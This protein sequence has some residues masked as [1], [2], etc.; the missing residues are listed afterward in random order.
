MDFVLCARP[1]GVLM[2]FEPCGPITR[3][4]AAGWR[5]DE[6]ADEMVVCHS[7]FPLSLFGACPQ[8]LAVIIRK[9]II[10]NNEAVVRPSARPP[11]CVSGCHIT[12][13]LQLVPTQ[14]HHYN[15]GSFR[16]LGTWATLKLH[17]RLSGTLTGGQFSAPPKVCRTAAR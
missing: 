4:P 12:I 8:T 17:H 11:A 9:W 2:W 3:T 13:T 7:F 6:W 15:V 10:I 16:S 14:T 1:L 5:V